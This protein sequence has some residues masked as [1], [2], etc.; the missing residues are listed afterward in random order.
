MVLKRS[1]KRSAKLDGPKFQKWGVLKAQTGRSLDIKVDGSKVLSRDRPLWL[2]GTVHF[3]RHS[4]HSLKNLK[5]KMV[6]KKTY[7]HIMCTQKLT[8]LIQILFYI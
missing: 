2:I 3:R 4:S 5:I 7:L 1:A 8:G 6:H